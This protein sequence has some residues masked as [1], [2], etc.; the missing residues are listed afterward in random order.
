MAQGRVRSRD[1]A[2]TAWMSGSG[3]GWY[4]HRGGGLVFLMKE[5]CR[6]TII[7]CTQEPFAGVLLF[8]RKCLVQMRGGAY[9]IV[10]AVQPIVQRIEPGLV[11]P[12]RPVQSS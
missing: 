2:S 6:K 12:R 9:G 4:V 5:L 1:G 7:G 10:A 11:Q 3:D 8:S